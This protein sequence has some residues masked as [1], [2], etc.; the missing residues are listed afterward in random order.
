MKTIEFF[1]LSSVTIL[2]IV[3]LD[4]IVLIQDLLAASNISRAEFW[5]GA[6]TILLVFYS[7][8][9]VLSYRH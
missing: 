9:Y 5:S 2:A 8:I 1:A 4:Q 7:A 3:A 6:A